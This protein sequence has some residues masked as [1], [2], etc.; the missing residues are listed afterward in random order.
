MALAQDN[1]SAGVATTAGSISWN[2]TISAGLSNSG[3]IV[4]A[5]TGA[6]SG[7]DISS[8]VWDQSGANQSL[9]NTVN[10]VAAKAATADTQVRSFLWYFHNPTAGTSKTILVTAASSCELNAGA[11]SLSGWDGTFNAASPQTN[12]VGASTNPTVN[13]TSS[14]SEWA[15][16]C[17]GSENNN[18]GLFTETG[19]KIFSTS[20]GT[21]N[22]G[23]GSQRKPPPNG[24]TTMN[25]TGVTN[26]TGAASVGISIIPAAGPTITQQPAQQTIWENQTA[27][28]SVTATGVGGLTYQWSLNGSP[29]GGATNSSYTTGAQTYANNGDGYK[30]TVTDSN[31]STATIQVALMVLQVGTPFYY[32][33]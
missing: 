4:G 15:I 28:F 24:T 23:G 32:K 2:H 19:T 11:I 9:S 17:F 7:V 27:T 21:S 3:L 33:A 8:V 10:A 22:S 16:D 29:I 18:Q 14:G 20:V 12:A 31:S 25:W 5:A 1:I 30:C 13:V 6:N 26:T